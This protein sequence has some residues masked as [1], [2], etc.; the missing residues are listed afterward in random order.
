MTLKF[1]MDFMKTMNTLNWLD[2]E[3]DQA[4]DLPPGAAKPKQ[5]MDD[6]TAVQTDSDSANL[7]VIS[8]LPFFFAAAF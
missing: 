4:A 2:Q 3:G 1:L 8:V 5:E 7:D 6:A